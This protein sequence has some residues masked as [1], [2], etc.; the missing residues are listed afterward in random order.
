M[1]TRRNPYADP[2]LAQA[3]NNIASMFAPPSGSDLAGYATA[4][5]KRAEDERR[6]QAWREM[7]APTADNAV[8][9]RFGVAAGLFNPSQS[10]YTV[11]QNTATTRRGQD[12]D[13]ATKL[14]QTELQQSGETTRTMLAPVGQ[15]ATRFV[16]PA[17]AGTYGVPQQ[18]IGVVE[19]KPGEQSVLPDGRVLNGP[20]PVLGMDQY[21]AKEAEAARRSGLISDQQ[22]A[23]AVMG[24]QAGTPVQVIGP[25]GRPRLAS[26]G[27]AMRTGA[28]PVQDQ[29][30]RTNATAIL[31]DG[32]TQVPAM[33]GPDGAWYHAQTG[34]RLPPEVRV[35]E[36]A[37]PQGANEQLGITTSNVS[38]A[39]KRAAEV[40]RTLNLLDMYEK[41]VDNN[42]GALGLVGL[43][44]GTAQNAAATIN[45]VSRAFGKD[46]PQ[47]NEAANELRAG[48]S[49]VAPQLFDPSIPE[50]A[51]LQGALAYGL[52]R[53][54]NPSGEVSRQAYERALERVQG[55]GLLAN[56]QSA[57]A[58]INS[59]RN[60]LNGELSAIGALRNPATARTTTGG[61]PLAGAPQQPAAPQQPG[62]VERWTRDANGRLVKVQ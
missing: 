27:E 41:L 33:Q 37:K 36:M 9:D 12:V 7:T 2:A 43:I 57:K 17:L 62:A 53:T 60:V 49:K 50:A 14:R 31:P 32:R 25:D 44:R 35:V 21:L 4:A 24:K 54:E 20:A 59:F 42:P 10:Y 28:Q 51:F 8:R 18:Q 3:F 34:E 39:N 15:G 30:K 61:V 13:A 1:P 56:T 58:Q 19:L 29:T 6:L 46:I 52:A 55:G 26:P 40:T 47:I 38:D 22:I 11:D 45:D 16:P 48:L 23:D 5:S